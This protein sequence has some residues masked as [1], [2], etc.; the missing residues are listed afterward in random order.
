MLEIRMTITHPC[1]LRGEPVEPGTQVAMTPEDAQALLD[2]C[3]AELVDPADAA[4]LRTALAEAFQRAAQA[5]PVFG[6]SNEGAAESVRELEQAG[7][8]RPI[9]FIWP[10]RDAQQQ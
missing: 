6:Q 4:P 1:R 7:R 2:C 8:P 9:G 5:Q 3:R 10:D